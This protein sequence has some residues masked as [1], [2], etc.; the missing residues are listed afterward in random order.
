MNLRIAGV[1]VGLVLL[2]F[3]VGHTTDY[4]ITK[5]V[6]VGPAAWVPFT[7][8]LC[9]SPDGVHLAYFASNHLMVSDTLGKSREVWRVE[10]GQRPHKFEWVSDHEIAIGTVTPHMLP[11]SASRKTITVVDIDTGT[12][13]E[14]VKEPLIT[15]DHY[16]VRAG[17]TF[18]DG[19]LLTVEGNAYYLEK[20]TTGQW[21]HRPRG[22]EQETTKQAH[23][24]APDSSASKKD[25]HILRWG[26]EALYLVNLDQSDSTLL[27]EMVS[28]PL[29][30]PTVISADGHYIVHGGRIVEIATGVHITLDTAYGDSPEGIVGCGFLFTS[31]NPTSTEVLFNLGCDGEHA[32]G[33][34]FF[35]DWVGTFNYETGVFTLFDTLLNIPMSGCTAPVYAP[36][37]L[38]IAFL[39]SDDH[40]AFIIYRKEK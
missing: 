12:G 3:S 6:E 28:P 36:D 37:G 14:A 15:L 35:V 27:V 24:L 29:G 20:V 1:V 11:D 34:E 19:P 30:K 25:N 40:K 2:S 10:D 31:F 23:W 18:I 22:K 32:N 13:R 17:D 38:K 5:V 39:D 33:Q 16:S 4:E 7:G 8:P 26:D 9:W 21:L